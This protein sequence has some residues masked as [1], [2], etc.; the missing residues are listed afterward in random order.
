MSYDEHELW[1]VCNILVGD[2]LYPDYFEIKWDG[3]PTRIPA[4]ETRVLPRYLADHFA[5]HLADYI[6]SVAGIMLHDQGLREPILDRILI[7][8][9]DESDRTYSSNDQGTNEPTAATPD[10]LAGEHI[11]PSNNQAADLRDSQEGA[12][13]RRADTPVQG[14]SQ[15]SGGS[16]PQ[17]EERP[18]TVRQDDTRTRDEDNQASSDRKQSA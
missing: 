6:M 5:S 17:G 10:R 3:V 14:L 2:L 13:V 18:R 15:T 7:H 9:A 11:T 12:A 4:G 16:F 1:V 8:K